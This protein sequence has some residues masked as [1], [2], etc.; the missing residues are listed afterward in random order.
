M[1]YAEI[2]NYVGDGFVS[3]DLPTLD[4]YD[5]RHGRV[6]SRVPLSSAHEVDTAVKAARAA[7]PGWAATPIKERGAGVQGPRRV[8]VVKRADR[9]HPRWCGR[10][11]IS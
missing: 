10:I 4:A 11:S 3:A 1:K 8:R 7:F 5:P 2:R 9:R 6:I